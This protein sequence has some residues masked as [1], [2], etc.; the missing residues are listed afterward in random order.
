M[1]LGEGGFMKDLVGNE[2]WDGEN[3]SNGIGWMDT[4]KNVTITLRSNLFKYII[5]S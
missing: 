5:L 3:A 1:G 4:S 2:E